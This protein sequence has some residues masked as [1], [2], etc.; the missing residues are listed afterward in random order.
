MEIPAFLCPST[1]SKEILSLLR[2]VTMTTCSAGASV[3]SMCTE[4]FFKPQTIMYMGITTTIPT[5]SAVLGVSRRLSLSLTFQESPLAVLARSRRWVLIRAIT[6]SGLL[7]LVY[8]L[9]RVGQR[10]YQRFSVL[11]ELVSDMLQI[12]M[13]YLPSNILC[14]PRAV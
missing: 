1:C 6:I 4:A 3:S 9:A 13:P 10:L 8:S 5:V 7:K 11:L 12:R 2:T 14:F